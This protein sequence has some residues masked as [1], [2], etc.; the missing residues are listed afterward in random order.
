ML[1]P[2]AKSTSFPPCLFWGLVKGG[3]KLLFLLQIDVTINKTGL[4]GGFWFS[5]TELCTITIKDILD[6]NQTRII[7]IETS[8][9]LPTAKKLKGW[10]TDISDSDL[11][12]FSSIILNVLAHLC[13]GCNRGTK[14]S[15]PG[16]WD[17]K[18]CPLGQLLQK[19]TQ[20]S[21]LT[22][23][24]FV[25]KWQRVNPTSRNPAVSHKWSTSA[26]ELS[27]SGQSC[28]AGGSLTSNISLH[29]HTQGDIPRVNPNLQACFTNPPCTVCPQAYFPSI[30]FK[31]LLWNKQ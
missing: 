10:R 2:T 27:I 13:I 28:P 17:N 1:V 26:L 12:R 7:Q 31:L 18:Y 11:V 23:Q 20:Q 8:F 29:K 24:E 15:R 21:L 5:S 30:L 14:K 4:I 19:G 6:L 25:I 3:K 22:C 16:S 9:Y